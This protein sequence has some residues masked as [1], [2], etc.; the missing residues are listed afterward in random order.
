MGY[1]A[2]SV[3]AAPGNSSAL[4]PPPDGTIPV[5]LPIGNPQAPQQPQQQM[6]PGEGGDDSGDPMAAILRLLNEKQG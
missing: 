5:R 4:P 3:P 1:G 6:Q 2:A